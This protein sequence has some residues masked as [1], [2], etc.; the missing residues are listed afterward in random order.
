MAFATVAEAELWKL[1]QMRPGDRL[2]LRPISLGDTRTLAK[3]LEHSIETIS[4]LT[5]PSWG[6]DEVSV[7]SPIVKVI[8]EAGHCC[9][10]VR[11]AGDRALL[12]DFGEDDF[13][14]RQMFHMI[15]FIDKH[16]ATLILGVQELN[17]GV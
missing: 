2:Q 14:L 8:R 5:K 11:Q 16:R 13:K 15:N 7:P 3:N 10:T 17:S 12:L 9:I 1:G 6:S 4:P